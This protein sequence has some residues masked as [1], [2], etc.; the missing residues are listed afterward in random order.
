MMAGLLIP[1][2]LFLAR[3]PQTIP[4]S[5]DG[6]WLIP[7]DQ[8]MCVELVAEAIRAS[9][10]TV[11][12]VDVNRPGDDRGLVQQYVSPGDIL[13]ILLRPDGARLEGVE[14]FTPSELR[15]FVRGP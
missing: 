5:S 3:M 10:R 8:V 4:P 6:S 1:P 15:R 11:K 9:G 2:T 13:P 7:A 12:L 14:S